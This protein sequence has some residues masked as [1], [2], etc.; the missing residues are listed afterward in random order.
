MKKIFGA[1]SLSGKLLLEL[2]ESVTGD[3]FFMTKRGMYK[4]ARRLAMGESLF[5]AVLRNLDRRGFIKKIDSDKYLITPKAIRHKKYLDAESAKWDDTKWDGRWKIVIFDIPEKQKS[6]RNIFR[7]FLKRK[8]FVKL[9]NS[10]FVSPYVNF[11]VLDFV[12]KELEISRYVSFLE[13]ESANTEDDSRLRD[14]FGL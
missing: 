13:A 8:G 5:N 4:F 3:D 9:Q 1:I 14:K 12:R 11:R 6:K 2:I 10:V 7:G